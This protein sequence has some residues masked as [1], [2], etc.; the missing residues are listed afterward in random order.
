MDGTVLTKDCPQGKS[1]K[2]R[3]FAAGVLLAAAL[4]VVGAGVSL[5]LDPNRFRIPWI[6]SS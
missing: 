5:A 3:W 2:W 4:L 6:V 1:L